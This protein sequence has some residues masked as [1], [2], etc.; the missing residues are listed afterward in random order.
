MSRGR[1]RVFG[2]LR[3]RSGHFL[4]FGINIVYA[5]EASLHHA[6]TENPKEISFERKWGE[7]RWN[8]TMFVS[9]DYSEAH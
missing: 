6:N 4:S 1:Y 8:E 5:T 7:R 2:I 9:F 3:K